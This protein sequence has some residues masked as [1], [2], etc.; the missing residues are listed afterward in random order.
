MSNSL[1]PHLDQHFI[2]PDLDPNCL[3]RLSADDK[4][5]PLVGKELKVLGLGASNEYWYPNALA[6]NKKNMNTF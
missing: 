1:G 4:K 6:E 3:Q 5:L 2:M